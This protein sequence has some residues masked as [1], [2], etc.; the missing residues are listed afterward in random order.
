MQAAQRDEE[1]RA[2]GM[3]EHTPGALIVEEC[4][5]GGRTVAQMRSPNKLVCINSL[6]DVDPPGYRATEANA[7]RLVAMWNACQDIATESFEAVATATDPVTRLHWLA[8]V[9][10]AA[11]YEA[12]P[13]LLAEGR[14]DV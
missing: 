9:A 10:E 13:A 11:K 12:M 5:D 7:R 1:G 3:A 14:A 2:E 8:N 6:G 4:Y